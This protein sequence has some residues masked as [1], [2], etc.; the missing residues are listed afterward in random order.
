M[1]RRWVVAALLLV[2]GS[3]FVRRGIAAPP[4]KTVP[5]DPY[6]AEFRARVN[7]EVAAGAKRLLAGLEPKADVVLH[8]HENVVGERALLL[9]TLLKCGIPP[10]TP[11]VE[12]AFVR[13]R[14]AP[15]RQTYD[16]AAVLLAVGARYDG[17]VDPFA[18]D[19]I[20]ADGRRVVPPPTRRELDP[21][22]AKCLEEGVR[23]LE[24]NLEFDSLLAASPGGEPVKPGPAPK[25]PPKGA[26][27][28]PRAWGYPGSAGGGAEHWVDASCTQY[29]LLGLKAAAR[30]GIAV[31]PGTWA[32]VLEALLNWQEATGP[33][34]AFRG[35]EVRGASRLEWT[36]PAQA[37][38]FGYTPGLDAT[39]GCTVA[40]AAGMMICQSELW[41]SPAF[42]PSLEKRA[43]LGI[44]DALAWMQAHFAVDQNPG[45]KPLGAKP[46]A[47]PM[48]DH[49]WYGAYLYGLE[50]MGV[51]ARVR[52]LGPHDWYAEG[53][54]RILGRRTVRGDAFIVPHDD[55]FELLFLR[56]A[57]FRTSQS[58]ITPSDGPP[59]PPPGGPG[60]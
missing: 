32:S 56:R 41:G 47:G 11:A 31:K 10:E 7:A 51:L 12:T 43:R 16:V 30:C 58:A 34:V 9:L 50:R 20:G 8:P 37:R 39:G 1:H 21:E 46:P 25:P 55:C 57:S 38:G 53:A 54:R 59:P 36:E 27:P 52:F 35:N 3:P 28:G 2:F 24:S 40:G 14:S 42:P 48:A 33:K 44:R 23:F 13:L 5:D 26:L 49:P 45:E 15:L 19:V 17:L 60:K 22:D 18:L 4:T 6:P 29:A